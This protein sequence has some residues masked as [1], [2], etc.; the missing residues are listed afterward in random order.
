MK[1][2]TLSFLFIALCAIMT[3]ISC[4]ESTLRP[5]IEK[6]DPES[7]DVD[8]EETDTIIID[9]LTPVAHAGH[10]I[11]V[12]PPT[13]VELDGSLSYDPL[14]FYPLKYYWSFVQRPAQSRSIIEDIGTAY[15]TVN[16]D[17]PGVFVFELD[18]QN[19]IGTWSQNP[20]QVVVFS[21]EP[22]KG[23]KIILTWN[24]RVDLDLHLA[25]DDEELYK[26][27]YD[28]NFCNRMPIWGDPD[29]TD[30][31]P[32]YAIDFTTGFGPE[33]IYI[34]N[35]SSST[36]RL[37]V[38]RFSSGNCTGAGCADTRAVVVVYYDEIEVARW[39]RLMPT[40]KEVWDIAHIIWPS[41]EIIEINDSY[42]TTLRGC[43]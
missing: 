42:I 6:I 7:P 24:T 28:C 23:L 29:S 37:T 3:F 12:H 17:V 15:P 20:N 16:I 40:N 34:K 27:P 35:P 22:E 9:T 14:G 21:Q 19:D 11:T 32:V 18:V 10:N 5:V 1:K 8:S 30:D 26:K 36:Y 4:N 43:Y 33:E 2:I 25:I 13:D 38:L 41:R 31:N 39:T